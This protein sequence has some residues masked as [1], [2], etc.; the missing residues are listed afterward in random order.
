MLD[1][2]VSL[3]VLAR[4]RYAGWQVRHGLGIPYALN[5]ATPLENLLRMDFS[6][7]P[8]ESTPGR[9]AWAVGLVGIAAAGRRGLPW[10]GL[11]LAF[12]VLTLGPYALP[13]RSLPIP[14]WSLKTA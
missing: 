11:A 6:D 12:S 7:N 10:L 14:A 13:D 2:P 4:S 8:L 3:Q 9:L 5:D 1:L